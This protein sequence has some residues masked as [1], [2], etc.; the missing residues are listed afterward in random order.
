MDSRISKKRYAYFYSAVRHDTFSDDARDMTTE[1]SFDSK[2]VI[3]INALVA[4]KQ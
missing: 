2:V 4:S 1:N 3:A